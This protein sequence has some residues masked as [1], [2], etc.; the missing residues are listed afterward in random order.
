VFKAFQE[1]VRA[2]QLFNQNDKLLL[3]TSGGIDSVVLAHLLKAGEFSFALAHCNFQL[4]RPDSNFDEEFCRQLAKTLN[5]DFYVKHFDVK[6]HQKK[7]KQ[8]VQMAA[9]E[10]RYTW[11][12]E[13]IE[14]QSFD[15][16]LTAHHA[17]DVIETLFINLMRGTGINGLKGIPEKAGQIVRPL[18]AFTKEE[19]LAYATEQ[20]IS[21]RLD[22]SNLE[23]KYER[24]FLRLNILPALK[25][26]HPQFEK[27]ML[28][29]VANFKEEGAI[30]QEFLLEKTKKIVKQKAD[31]IY[32]N[33]KLLL[34]EKHH[35]S[36]LKFTLGNFGFNTT[37]LNDIIKN[38]SNN[39]LIGKV[40]S[41]STHTLTIDREQL[42][43]RENKVVDNNLLV[44]SSLEELKKSTAFKVKKIKKFSAPA[45]N[46][47]VIESSK[48]VFPL[49]LRA[50]IKGE[51]FKPFGM[52]GFKLMSDFL[53]EQKLNN[54]EK[55]NCKLLINGNNEVIWV[56]GFRSDER[57]R[58]NEKNTD[59]LKFTVVEK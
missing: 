24:N 17:N 58:A 26:L 47:L 56:V 15:Y 48:L 35:K 43:V 33:K 51:K 10:L 9:R 2:K 14:N 31:L 57:Y 40:L 29:N 39:G 6:T 8:S 53:K 12:K 20:A 30:V 36:I 37:Q 19:I 5:V 38:I 4:R 13:L 21:F 18:L 49:T 25:K 23:E 28:Q 22:K 3:A 41:T 1:Q 52:K 16:L 42:I 11:F 32:L 55:E 45:T 7:S 44:Y 59:F 54:F 34:E 50:K 46:E 27:T